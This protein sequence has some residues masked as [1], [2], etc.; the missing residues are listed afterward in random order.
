MY[1][2]HS[3]WNDLFNIMDIHGCKAHLRAFQ[4]NLNSKS[5]SVLCV[6]WFKV[7]LYCGLAEVE[8]YTYT[9]CC[10]CSF[11][12]FFT[13]Q[14]ASSWAT[15]Q[16]CWKSFCSSCCHNSFQF[17]IRR[18]EIGKIFLKNYCILPFPSPPNYWVGTIRILSL[19]QRF[20]IWKVAFIVLDS[21]IYFCK[22]LSFMN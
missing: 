20:D 18:F 17:A 13:L 16:G 14:G 15:L 12:F 4:Q 10:N 11:C 2:I 6:I 22:L 9:C 5:E 21:S 3:L 19:F 7:N 1:Y 8:K